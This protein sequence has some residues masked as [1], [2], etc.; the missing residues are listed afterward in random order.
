MKISKSLG[1]DIPLSVLLSKDF[2]PLAYRYFL[3]SARYDSPANFTWG[4]L[5][6]A[7]NALNRLYGIFADLGLKAGEVSKGYEEKFS[8]L[9]ND[10]LDMPRA[11]ALVWELLK[12]D[13][14]A[15][16]DKKATLLQFDKVLG[17]DL[18]YGEEEIEKKKENVP[19]EM[20]K[21]AEEREKAR[22]AG[23]WAL[24]DEL[25]K[26]IKMAGWMIRDTET[27]PEISKK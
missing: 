17:L 10:D 8:R 20:F 11:L 23:N 6:V 19:D 2:D 5:S 12:D 9:V 7:Q 1:N 4:A 26:K 21:L 16:A 13:S 25:R 24:A 15:K 14:V 3:L 22:K 27:G 18:L